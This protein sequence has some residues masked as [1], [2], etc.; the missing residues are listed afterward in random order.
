MLFRWLNSRDA[1]EAG[2]RLADK[3]PPGGQSGSGTL[4]DFMR[5][6][7]AEMHSLQLNFYKK[8]RFANAFKWRL[9]EKGVAAETAD[10]AT[11]S[12]V[13]SIFTGSSVATEYGL[14]APAPIGAASTRNAEQLLAKA[15]ELHTA[16]E[17]EQAIRLYQELLEIQP[18]NAEAR[19]NLG[20]A[21]S[22]LGRFDEAAD[23][24]RRAIARKPELATAHANLGSTL[25]SQ[26]LPS[27]AEAPLRR[28][29]KIRASDLDARSNLGRVLVSSGRLT[30]A[31]S[32][33]QRVLKVAPRHTEALYG[34]AL[35]ARADGRFEE[36]QTL[37]NQVLQ[38]NPRMT[39]AWSALVSTRRMTEADHDWLDRAQQMAASLKNVP[40]EADLRFAIGKY[41]DDTGRFKQAFESYT[42]ANELQKTLALPYA[43]AL[44]TRFVKDM[45]L[46]YT[47]D[48]LAQITTGTSDS[49]KPVFVVGMPR[50]GTS[51]VEQILASH[52]AVAAAGELEFWSDAMRK[53][54]A[55]A[56]R[57]IL[58]E[59]SRR[60][61]GQKYLQILHG[62]GATARRVIDKMPGNADY[63]GIIHSIFPK[64]RVIYM[65][66][67]PI[68]TCLSCYFQ[69][70]YAAVNFATDLSNLAHYYN[71]HRR[72]MKHWRATL[73][74]GTILDVPYEELV[75]D[76]A[77]WTRRILDFLGLE[78]DERCLDFH[79][80]Q[81]PVVT[82]SFWQVR[83][84]IYGYSVQRWRNYEKMLGPLL[85]LQRT[86]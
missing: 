27:Q 34:L 44:R 69:P 5:R 76:Q 67:D 75:S 20:D 53:L 8:A 49:D 30:E 71:E 85:E 55:L 2:A 19:N 61:L 54:R 86:H 56:R 46:T 52:P 7:V 47:P 57:S 16:G 84:K 12:L 42:R 6:A 41:Y 17:F 31:R 1:V 66:R 51:L 11:Q 36:A 13:M 38:I 60:E 28:A 58:A 65:Q 72:L 4:Q 18:R 50:S 22:K 23:Q 29:L 64:A 82:T 77:G 80:T 79:R 14:Q 59:P 68:D 35:V 74:P 83:Q 21:F 78:W 37:F 15:T 39:R 70:F 40:D 81:R 45:I 25:L 43:P 26:G 62:H 48:T 10:A 24:F 33:L 73:P 3:F 63:L 9:L 32:H